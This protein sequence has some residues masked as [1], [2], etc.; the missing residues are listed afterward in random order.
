MLEPSAIGLPCACPPTRER[1]GCFPACFACALAACML[2]L[3]R[4]TL[5]CMLL[6]GAVADAAAVAVRVEN[7]RSI[8]IA[9]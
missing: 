1:Y 4:I 8:A 2:C 6:F 7:A 3:P 9:L 5:H